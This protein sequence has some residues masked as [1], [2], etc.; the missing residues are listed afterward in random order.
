MKSLV[1]ICEDI[2][3]SNVHNRHDLSR[4][5]LPSI[6]IVKLQMLHVSRAL[7]TTLE[8]YSNGDIEVCKT[9]YWKSR[10]DLF[11]EKTIIDIKRPC[12]QKGSTVV[13]KKKCNL[14]NGSFVN[15]SPK[16]RG[17]CWCLRN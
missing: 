5:N 15:G 6:I 16:L 13:E 11:K 2:V 4:L 17:R 10:G 7:S 9:C 12:Y 14:C 1:D 3:L 8:I